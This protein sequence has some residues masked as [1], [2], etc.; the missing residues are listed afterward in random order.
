M[1]RTGIV[2]IVCL[3]LVFSMGVTSFA[4]NFYDAESASEKSVISGEEYTGLLPPGSVVLLKNS[5]KRLMIIGYLQSLS[6]DPSDKVYTYS[7]CLFPE[8]YLSADEV[9]L[10]DKEQIESISFIGYQDQEETEFLE[11]VEDYLSL[12]QASTE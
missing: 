3:S 7:G 9:Y 8:G 12:L 6:D 5:E 2:L 10:F 1:R 4:E 11:K